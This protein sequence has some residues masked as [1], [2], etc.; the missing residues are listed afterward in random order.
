MLNSTKENHHHQNMLMFASRQTTESLGV[1][2]SS[3]LDIID[4]LYNNGVPYVLT[5]K[6][7]QDP[8]EVTDTPIELN[9]AKSV[10]RY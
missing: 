5:V 4:E 7:N 2:L 6:L 1:T 10:Y 3:V 9:Q 8:L